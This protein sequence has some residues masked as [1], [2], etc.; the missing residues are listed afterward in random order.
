MRWV[1]GALVL[2]G[3][4]LLAAR[5]ADHVTAADHGARRGR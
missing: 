4:A 1:L 2:A 3:A 5:R